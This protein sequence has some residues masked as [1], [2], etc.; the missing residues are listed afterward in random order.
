MQELAHF[1]AVE[2]DARR[3]PLTR[4]HGAP[5]GYGILRPSIPCDEERFIA[6][7]GGG[8]DEMIRVAGVD[9]PLSA[10][11]DLALRLHDD[12]DYAFAT[13]L[14]R[15]IDSGAGQVAL[16]PRD[17]SELL[18]ALERYPVLGLDGLRGEL[19]ERARARTSL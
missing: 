15:V 12:G 1:S 8:S 10:L 9:V 5:D 4:S 14:G 18:D 2:T 13:R 3:F 19:L 6:H 16:A 11:S 7:A 17:E